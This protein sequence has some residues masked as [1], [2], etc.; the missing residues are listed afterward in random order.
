MVRNSLRETQ[1]A[2]RMAAGGFF[3]IR[4]KNL[5][6]LEYDDVNPID[7]MDLNLTSLSYPLTPERV[8]KIR[9]MDP[10][11]FPFFALYAVINGSVAGQV[12][13]FRLPVVTTDGHDE[14]GGLWAVCTHPSLPVKVWHPD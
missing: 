4:R 3:Y 6:I 14:V 13:V 11:P 1:N 7:V 10:R 5:E 9:Q 2:I 12:G 8:E